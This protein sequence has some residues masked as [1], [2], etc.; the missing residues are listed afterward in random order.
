M[1]LWVEVSEFYPSTSRE[2]LFENTPVFFGVLWQFIQPVLNEDT[3]S[4]IW[5][6][7]RDGASR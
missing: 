2:I 1:K 4:K 5:L 7:P 6:V 3:K